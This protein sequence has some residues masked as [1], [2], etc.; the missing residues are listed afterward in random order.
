ME[1][2]LKEHDLAPPPAMW[3]YEEI[4]ERL[5]PLQCEPDITRL[6]GRLEKED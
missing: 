2:F 5:R 3:S 1:E 4:G 6:L